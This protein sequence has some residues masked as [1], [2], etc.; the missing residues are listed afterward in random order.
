MKLEMKLAA[1]LCVLFFTASLHAAGRLNVVMDY[2][3]KMENMKD[4]LNIALEKKGIPCKVEN[5]IAKHPEVAK[6]L[7]Q[8]RDH[9]L[10]NSGEVK[11]IALRGAKGRPKKK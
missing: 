6:T 3:G 8:K 4:D 5:V 2:I 10:A 9:W 1:F 11:P 7:R